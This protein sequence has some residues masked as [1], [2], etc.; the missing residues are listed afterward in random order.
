M[1]V[2][3]MGLC[4]GWDQG[5]MGCVGV[6]KS[7]GRVIRKT[8]LS[9]LECE[10]GI[11]QWPIWLLGIREARRNTKRSRDTEPPSSEE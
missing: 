8:R 11:R 10:S 1:T 3:G 5:S 9:S 7:R 4:L 2:P 6:R